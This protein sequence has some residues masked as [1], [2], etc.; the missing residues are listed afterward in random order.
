MIFSIILFALIYILLFITFL[1]LLNNKI[2]HGP[3]KDQ[4]H[5]TKAPGVSDAIASDL[6]NQRG[7]ASSQQ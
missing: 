5:H 4:D 7:R 3:D 2:Q 1:Y 6:F